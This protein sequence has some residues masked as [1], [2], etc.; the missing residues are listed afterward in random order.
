MVCE[1]RKRQGLALNDSVLWNT[2]AVSLKSFPKGFNIPK[3]IFEI[4][5]DYETTAWYTRCVSGM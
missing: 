4:A 5:T 3:K 1:D 2:M